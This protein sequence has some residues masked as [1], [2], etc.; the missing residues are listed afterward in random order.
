MA[1]HAPHHDGDYWIDVPSPCFGMLVSGSYLLCLVF[2]P[3]LEIGHGSMLI[4]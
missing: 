3:V 2:M 1:P 4:L